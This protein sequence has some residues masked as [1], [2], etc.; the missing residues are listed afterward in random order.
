MGTQGMVLGLMYAATV[1]LLITGC[2]L[3]YCAIQR[4]VIGEVLE[5]LAILALPTTVAV[6]AYGFFNL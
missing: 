2:A 4:M 6:M 1:L 5:G 3:V